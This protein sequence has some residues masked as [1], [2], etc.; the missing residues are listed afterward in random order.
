MFSKSYNCNSDETTHNADAYIPPKLY[1]KSK[2]LMRKVADTIID[3]IDQKDERKPTAL[4]EDTGHW[5]EVSARAEKRRDKD[6][7]TKQQ[8]LDYHRMLEINRARKALAK[9]VKKA[10]KKAATLSTEGGISDL[11]EQ[12]RKFLGN[13]YN[14]IAP[15]TAEED[16][17]GFIGKILGIALNFEMPSLDSDII[18]YLKQKCGFQINSWSV[19]YT[20]LTMTMLAA[21]RS[22]YEDVLIVAIHFVSM[23]IFQETSVVLKTIVPILF[24]LR[25]IRRLMAIADK[26][27]RRK[28]YEIAIKKNAYMQAKHEEILARG[29]DP[30]SLPETEGG[31]LSDFLYDL[32]SNTADFVTSHFVLS[33][34]DIIL[35]LAHYHLFPKSV[36]HHC[37]LWLGK[38]E[39]PKSIPEAMSKI[40]T[41]VANLVKMSEAYYDGQSLN[42]ILLAADPAREAKRKFDDLSYQSSHLY[43]GLPDPHRHDGRTWVREAKSLV[44]VMRNMQGKLNPYHI[45]T[46]V[47]NG[48]V[49]ILMQKLAEVES[50]LY[51]SKRSPPLGIVLCGPPGIGKS[52]LL[53]YCAQLHSDVMGRSF[54]QNHIFERV[55]TSDYFDGYDPISHPIIHYSEIGSE[56]AKRAEQLPKAS[57]M[58]VL[59]LC[60]SLPFS[61]NMSVAGVKGTVFARPELVLVDTNNE[62]MNLSSLVCN[63][64]AYE[65]RFVFLRPKVKPEYRVSSESAMLDRKKPGADFL[66]KWT[67][68]LFTKRP[69]DNTHVQV[70]HHMNADNPQHDI[71]QLTHTLQHLMRTHVEEEAKVL[72]QT[73][74]NWVKDSKDLVRAKL[75]ERGVIKPDG[76][77]EES[78]TVLMAV[79]NQMKREEALKDLGDRGIIETYDQALKRVHSITDEDARKE[80]LA[81]LKEKM[82]P[83]SIDTD[84]T[85]LCTEGYAAPVKERKVWNWIDDESPEGGHFEE[86]VEHIMS[87]DVLVVDASVPMSDEERKKAKLD[88]MKMR[89]GELPPIAF[90]LVD[91]LP[92]EILELQPDEDEKSSCLETE[93][94]FLPDVTT[95]GLAEEKEAVEET[96]PYPV[97]R[98]RDTPTDQTVDKLETSMEVVETKRVI[99]NPIQVSNAEEMFE[100]YLEKINPKSHPG[101]EVR[102]LCKC[103]PMGVHDADTARKRFQEF[104]RNAKRESKPMRKWSWKLILAFYFNFFEFVEEV[105]YSTW[106]AWLISL[107]IVTFLNIFVGM[108]LLVLISFHVLVA[109]GT[110]TFLKAIGAGASMA[111]QYA[112]GYIKGE[113][114][115]A[116]ERVQCYFTNTRRTVAIALAITAVGGLIVFVY[117]MFKSTSSIETES[118]FVSETEASKNLMATE[119]RFAMSAPAYRKVDSKRPDKMYGDNVRIIEP[120]KFQSK[121]EL[122]VLKA[123]QRN[124]RLARFVSKK[125]DKVLIDSKGVLI[126]L[127]GNIALVHLHQF[128]LEG[129]AFSVSY[130]AT[131]NSRD[132]EGKPLYACTDI[133]ARAE[134][135]PVS[136][137]LCVI[138]LSGTLFKDITVFMPD[139]HMNV[140]G[141]RVRLDAE[142]TS[143]AKEEGDIHVRNSFSGQIVLQEKSIKYSWKAHSRGK[144]GY[145][146]IASVPAGGWLVA[147]HSSGIST[148]HESHA[149]K[150]CKQMFKDV[151]DAFERSADISVLSM[152]EVESA[153][154]AGEPEGRSSLRHVDAGPIEYYGKIH[155]FNGNQKSNLVPTIFAEEK[156]FKKDLCEVL[157]D[158]TAGDGEFEPASM[159]PARSGSPITN[160]FQKLATIRLP[161]DLVLIRTIA[162]LL[163]GKIINNLKEMGVIGG[164]QPYD[165]TTAVN[166]S[167]NDDYCRRICMSTGGGFGYPGSKLKYFDLVDESRHIFEPSEPLKIDIQDIYDS[168]DVGK[169]SC[170]VFKGALKDEPRPK[171]KVDAHKTRVFYATPTPFLIVQKQVLG[172][173]YTTMISHSQAFYTAL[174]TDMHRDGHLIKKRLQKFADDHGSALNIGA[175]DYSGFDTSMPYGISLASANVVRRIMKAFGYNAD[176]LHL[177]DG[178]MTD[179]LFPFVDFFGDLCMVPGLQP[180]GKYGTAEDNSLR[181]LLILMYVWYKQPQLRNLDFFEYV[182]PILYGDDVVYAVLDDVKEFF[183]D[184]VIQRECKLIG[185]GYTSS[186][187]GEVMNPFI[188]PDD[189]EFLKRK[190]K[191]HKDLG[192]IVSVLH[193]QS[194]FKMLQW[195]APSKYVPI[196]EQYQSLCISA[197]TEFFFH[198]DSVS[199][200]DVLEKYLSSRLCQH[201]PDVAFTFPTYFELLARY[202]DVEKEE[203]S[204]CLDNMS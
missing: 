103:C 64:A 140:E 58:E 13:M 82:R 20:L 174:G 3:L 198:C 136:E 183:N 155:S 149:M 124:L 105:D 117:K 187:K 194:I 59:S 33:L 60:D 139:N 32:R 80:A 9:Q 159:K 16:K 108:I 7:Y 94:G 35:N 115:K 186:S 65:R 71:Y 51:R 79:V 176:Q 102:P 128:N 199:D 87:D 197:L 152:P 185:I 191:Y 70:T 158:D 12:L 53:T 19:L 177:V 26:Q 25:S 138:E 46:D 190:D 36:A 111:Q 184:L 154:E 157:K 131:L 135:Y 173:L 17:E 153:I 201:F 200:Y 47:L 77:V 162:A 8:S 49:R 63:V 196:H 92:T 34:R 202:A 116:T 137:D 83:V 4:E 147:I 169:R 110:T 45:H 23:G 122:N 30:N 144:C 141:F 21:S 179:L 104:L 133:L 189:M 146:V 69:I 130:S 11:P 192:R 97:V 100:N 57:I 165:V 106:T 99:P 127:K 37:K 150:V 118:D 91:E 48:R 114:G 93:T 88:A 54:E 148:T 74:R 44:E 107:S 72:V 73:E 38:I 170:A 98:S 42:E 204:D 125:G 22:F 55:V 134:I 76:T 126:G 2:Y 86:S 172:P 171:E 40:T 78:N 24:T 41:D 156:T 119:I 81:E 6:K 39:A 175:G 180:S 1:A 188:D 52:S 178:V 160:G 120:A 50:Q 142:E 14:Q 61:C 168:Y 145:P 43:F 167:E 113:L 29:L 112:V 68:D 28:A 181:N 10:A 129:N 75:I 121:D 164:W 151:F 31:R 132:Y 193:M 89:G 62:G 15:G 90:L 84:T 27:K 95:E 56:T 66:D 109:M 143:I 163:A 123:C 101:V 18:K 203:E 182:L 161:I 195:I 166:G 67:F 5:R 85:R 96:T